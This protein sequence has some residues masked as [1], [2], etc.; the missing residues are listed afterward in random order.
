MKTVEIEESKKFEFQTLRAARN[1]WIKEQS[2]AVE[3]AFPAWCSTIEAWDEAIS[4][5]QRRSKLHVFLP[6]E[7]LLGAPYFINGRFEVVPSRDTITN[8]P[9]NNLLLKDA[10]RL[11]VNYVHA[12][13]GHVKSFIRYAPTGES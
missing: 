13:L 6:T 12:Q 11:L 5:I 3:L 7:L 2:K 9:Q 1:H 10:Q 8:T 4:S